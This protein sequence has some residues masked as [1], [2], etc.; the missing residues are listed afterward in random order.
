M[1]MTLRMMMTVNMVRTI[2]TAITVRR[3]ITLKTPRIL[4]PAKTVRTVMMV[5]SMR[6]VRTA[7]THLVRTV[8]SPS[9][10]SRC[11]TSQQSRHSYSLLSLPSSTLRLNKQT[12]R[13]GE[14]WLGS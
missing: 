3:E 13:L 1:A 2:R 4:M 9:P 12:V 8:P 5:R 10:H 7:L 14:T 6:T 11:L